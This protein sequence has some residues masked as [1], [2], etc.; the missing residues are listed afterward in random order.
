V[1]LS[2]SPLVPDR[3][4]PNSCSASFAEA[5]AILARQLPALEFERIR[6]IMTD[7]KVLSD[8]NLPRAIAL[9]FVR[10]QPETALPNEAEYFGQ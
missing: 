9:S 4:V 2:A 1:E 5:V 10:F 7:P 6:A 3:P 8:P